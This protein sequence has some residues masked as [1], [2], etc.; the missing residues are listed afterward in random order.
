MNQDIMFTNEYRETKAKIAE[1][2]VFITDIFCQSAFIDDTY[3]VNQELAPFIKKKILD[4]LFFRVKNEFPDRIERHNNQ[5][6]FRKME[7]S[8]FDFYFDNISKNEA[9]SVLSFKVT[10]YTNETEPVATADFSYV[11]ERKVDRS[12]PFILLKLKSSIKNIIQSTKIMGVF[13]DSPNFLDIQQGNIYFGADITTSSLTEIKV[14][15]D[16]LSK[17]KIK[18]KR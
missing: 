5:N 18:R 12:I 1:S 13:E 2:L 4:D 3:V 14:I 7:I 6:L 10:Y 15:N 8:N 11:I 9:V 17:A 16:S